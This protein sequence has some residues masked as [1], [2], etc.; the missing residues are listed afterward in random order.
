ME[1]SYVIGGVVG[2]FVT[3]GT[4]QGERAAELMIR[5]L[6]G[7]EMEQITS[8]TQSPNVYMFDRK[9][10]TESRL[11]LSE[12]IARESVI[13]HEDKTFFETH[14]EDILNAF[15]LFFILFL[16]FLVVIFFIFL[17]KRKELREI[18]A[19]LKESRSEMESRQQGS[20]N[21]E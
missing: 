3:S 7:T 15:F 20:S 4:H 14:Q 10:L 11:I 9:A 18:K 13:S 2:G 19:S 12:Y 8:L 5:Y 16:I 1:D 6:S 17:Q 21:N